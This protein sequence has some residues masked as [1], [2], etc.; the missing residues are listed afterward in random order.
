MTYDRVAP[1]VEMDRERRPLLGKGWQD[2]DRPVTVT[3]RAGS[4]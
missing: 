2:R 3:L 1:I 4:S